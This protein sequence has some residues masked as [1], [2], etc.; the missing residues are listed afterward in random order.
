MHH[1]GLVAILLTIPTIIFISPFFSRIL[2]IPT[3]PIEI[4]LGSIA[5]YVGLLHDTEIFKIIAEA[6]F[7]FLM[8]LA[9]LEIDFK[10]ILKGDKLII[11]NSIISINFIFFIIF[12]CK[13]L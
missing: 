9:G 3:I 8:F 11:K 13:I 7:L 6:G 12:V 10:K 4:I 2:N 5:T 1:E